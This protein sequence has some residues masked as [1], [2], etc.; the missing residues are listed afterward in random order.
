MIELVRANDVVLISALEALLTSAGF[1]PFVFDQH[2][3][4]MEGSIGML[5]RRLCVPEEEGER[6]RAFL[7]EAGHGGELRPGNR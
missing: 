5:P 7:I 1:T 3:S 4:V 6:A 2:T